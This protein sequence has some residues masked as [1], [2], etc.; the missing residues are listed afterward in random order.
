MQTL[1]NKSRWGTP[2]FGGISDGFARGRRYFDD[3]S[4]CS[5]AAQPRPRERPGVRWNI[6]RQADGVE[7]TVKGSEPICFPLLKTIPL[8]RLSSVLCST[9][10][11]LHPWE[12]ELLVGSVLG[13]CI[14]ALHKHGHTSRGKPFSVLSGDVLAWL[15]LALI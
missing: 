2:G 9:A 14:L 4:P 5:R 10:H 7:N 11:E 3:I 1:E 8:A 6:T 12:G 15:S 13:F